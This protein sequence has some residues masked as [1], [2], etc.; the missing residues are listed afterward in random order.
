MSD[1]KKL[2]LL[3]GLLSF[4]LPPD[5]EWYP[6]GQ[7]GGAIP[8]DR[9]SVLHVRAERVEDAAQ[10]PNLS[11]M[12][13]GFLTGHVRPVATD[14]LHPFS[15]VGGQGFAW[16]YLEEWES[17]GPPRIQSVWLWVMG[18]EQTWTF[19]NFQ[20][21]AGSSKGMAEQIARTF[22]FAESASS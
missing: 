13:A 2:E 16:H 14:E 22:A 21:P 6:D 19:V 15:V 1:W 20:G 8:P 5:W 7:G 3:E 18:N 4:E 9:Q 17:E 12:L 10:L 11:R